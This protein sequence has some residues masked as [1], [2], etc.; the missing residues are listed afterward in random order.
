M[1]NYMNI[2]FSA[3]VRHINY[4]V[5]GTCLIVSFRDAHILTFAHSP[6]PSLF[7]S[8]RSHTFNEYN[9]FQCSNFPPN[10][11]GKRIFPELYG[12]R[13]TLPL[14][15]AEFICAQRSY[16]DYYYSYVM[17][18]YVRFNFSTSIQ[19]LSVYNSFPLNALSTYAI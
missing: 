10:Q 9:I 13:E 7:L 8:P 18:R 5:P 2:Q 17:V 14:I 4:Y 3:T 15:D 19:I 12:R 16:V 1:V 11:L 6:P